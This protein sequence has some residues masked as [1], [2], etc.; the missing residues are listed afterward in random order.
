M[1]E[2]KDL[3]ADSRFNDL[4]CGRMSKDVQK[5]RKIYDQKEQQISEKKEHFISKKVKTKKERNYP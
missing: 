4:I 2:K 1:R 5:S 3:N